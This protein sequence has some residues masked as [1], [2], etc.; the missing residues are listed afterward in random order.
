MRLNKKNRTPW[1]KEEEDKLRSIY[2]KTKKKDLPKE[3]INRTPHAIMS[4]ARL[5]NLVKEINSNKTS[6]IEPL[7]EDNLIAYYW[8]GLIFADGYINHKTNHLFLYSIDKVHITDFANFIE[9]KVISNKRQHTS[10]VTGITNPN[11]TTSAMDKELIPV[12]IKKFDFK[13]A[14]TYNPPNT[15]KLEKI[16]NTKEKFAAFIAGLIDGDGHFRKRDISYKIIAHGSW[17]DAHRWMNNTLIKYNL[18]TSRVNP[19][20]EK[21]GLSH[22]EFRGQNLKDFVLTLGLPLMKRKW[23]L[24]QQ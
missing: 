21:R 2:P 5:L 15:K 23:Y 12:L 16:F 8:I 20:I 22:F 7:L 24:E 14:K 6:S 10:I 9:G 3:F 4:R 18:T 1:S 13:P 11:Y 19:T 17:I